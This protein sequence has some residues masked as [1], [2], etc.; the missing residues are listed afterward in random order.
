MNLWKKVDIFFPSLS[1]LLNG[2]AMPNR[3]CSYCEAVLPVWTS[4][5]AQVGGG[6]SS[7]CGASGVLGW[8]GRPQD[9]CS[10]GVTPSAS[11]RVVPQ[12]CSHSALPSFHSRSDPGWIL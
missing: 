4:C 8:V 12:A 11:M 7:F 3:H 6:D 1:G 5:E 2:Q 9:D 10:G